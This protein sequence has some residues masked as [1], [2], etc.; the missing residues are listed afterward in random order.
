M[1]WLLPE[2][3]CMSVGKSTPSSETSERAQSAKRDGLSS[4]EKNSSESKAT[5]VQTRVLTLDPSR[6]QSVE[7]DDSDW[8]L[9][10]FVGPGGGGPAQ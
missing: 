6:G 8:F 1:R 10:L 7:T 2:N 4:G 5:Q 3:V 9:F